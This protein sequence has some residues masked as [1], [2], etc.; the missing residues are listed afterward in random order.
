[1]SPKHV[2]ITPWH[3]G[4]RDAVVDAAHGDHADRAAGAVHELDVGRQQVVDAVLV[5]RV[6]VAAADLHDLVVAAG[7]D[8]RDDLAASTRPSSAS[9]Y[10]STNFTAS[11]AQRDAGVNEQVVARP[12][13]APTRSVIT[14][15]S[16]PSRLA[17]REPVVGRGSSDAHRHAFVGA[18][19]AVRVGSA[20]HSITL[21]FS[22][23]SSCS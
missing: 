6:R 4:D 17:A 14:S 9:R 10:S 20:A 23:S 16:A 11:L 5:D 8:G 21:A 1:M 15:V 13:R 3:V 2:K 22:S 7:L 18:G 19:D 12:R